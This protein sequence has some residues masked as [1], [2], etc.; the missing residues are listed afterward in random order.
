MALELSQL[1]EDTSQ[2]IA[3][4]A[5]VLDTG[6]V[7]T[8]PAA[9]SVQVNCSG[10]VEVALVPLDLAAAL[11]AGDVA[12]I[13]LAGGRPIVLARLSTGTSPPSPPSPPSQPSSGTSYFVA[14]E[15][16]T[17]RGSAW[18]TDSTTVSQ[19]TNPAATTDTGAW[20]YGTG[21]RAALTGATITSCRVRVRRRA[22]GTAGDQTLHVYRTANNGRPAGVDVTRTAGPV[23]FAIAVSQAG[24]VDLSAAWGTAL[25]SSAG[26][27]IGIAGNP[28]VVIEGLDTDPRSGQLEIGWTR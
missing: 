11:H 25:V 16:R 6:I 17:Y 27:G 5:S 1:S 20:F 7:L 18:R 15:S 9:G 21:P 22:G 24:W 10:L 28:F 19:G 3:A 8:E 4:A 12:V 14:T 23:D 13:G 26:G 2:R